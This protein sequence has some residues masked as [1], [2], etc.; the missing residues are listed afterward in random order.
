MFSPDGPSFTALIAVVARDDQ[1]ADALSGNAPAVAK[2]LPVFGG[3]SAV[4]DSVITQVGAALY[5]AGKY[6]VFDNRHLATIVGPSR[7]GSAPHFV[8]WRAG[9]AAAFRLGVS[10]VAPPDHARENHFR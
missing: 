10:V 4:P 9:R 7:T 5:G 8:R 6:D 1:F 2:A 3:P